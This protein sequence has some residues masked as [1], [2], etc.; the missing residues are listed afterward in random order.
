MPEDSAEQPEAKL[1]TCNICNESFTHKNSLRQH[2]GEIKHASTDT[3]GA[4]L[5]PGEEDPKRLRCTMCNRSFNKE[6]WLRKH[7]WT[8]HATKVPD[9]SVKPAEDAK[10]SPTSQNP[11]VD[12]DAPIKQE[13][14]KQEDQD[15]DSVLTVFSCPVCDKTFD[16]QFGLDQHTK[17]KHNP[18]PEEGKISCEWCR[19]SFVDDLALQNHHKDKHIQVCTYCNKV[20]RT[21]AALEEHKRC[22]RHPERMTEPAGAQSRRQKEKVS[23]PSPQRFKCDFCNS[24]FHHFDLLEQHV[25]RHNLRSDDGPVTIYKCDFCPK[26]FYSYDEVEHHMRT[27]YRFSSPNPWDTD[28]QTDEEDYEDSDGESDGEDYNES[29]EEEEEEEEEESNEENADESDEESNEEP[30]EKPGENC[31]EKLDAELPS[32]PFKCSDCDEVF[33]FNAELGGHQYMFAYGPMATRE[34]K[35]EPIAG[36]PAPRFN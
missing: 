26:T 3:D 17:A 14:L 25:I 35:P 30:A 34:E 10:P 6:Y 7:M 5:D 21:K 18:K 24:S 1:P 12:S 15:Q 22:T 11:A 16:G 13:D 4:E 32:P 19:K 31:T 29:N 33:Y 28:G 9:A 36:P 8:K 27:T 2:R 20:F 23:E